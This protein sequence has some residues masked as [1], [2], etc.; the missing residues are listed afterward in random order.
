[1]I[2]KRDKNEFVVNRQDVEGCRRIN[3]HIFSHPRFGVWVFSDGGKLKFTIITS[4][5]HV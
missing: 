3:P 5:N 1:M 2:T 4:Q